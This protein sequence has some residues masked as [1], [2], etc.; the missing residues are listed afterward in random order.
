MN[1]KL[2]LV[3]IFSMFMG[4]CFCQPVIMESKEDALKALR[5]TISDSNRQCVYN[6]LG[7]TYLVNSRYSKKLIDSAFYYLR[8]AVDLGDSANLNNNGITNESLC[9][10]AQTYLWSGDFPNARRLYLQVITSYHNHKEKAKEASTWYRMGREFWV[11]GC[12]YVDVPDCYDRAIRLFEQVKNIPSQVEVMIDKKIFFSS[13]GN[14]LAEETVLQKIKAL[15]KSDN[16]QNFS[17]IYAKLA[18]EDRY[19]GNLNKALEYALEAVKYIAFETNTTNIARCYAEIALI[20]DDL[21]EPEKSI[22][23]YQK[24]IMERE[25]NGYPLY[26]FYR[27]VS[28]YVIQMVK[29]KRENEAIAMLQKLAR[30]RPPV[31][32]KEKGSLFQSFAY[33]YAAMKAYKLAETKFLQMI[34]EYAAGESNAEILSIAYY[35]ISKFYVDNGQYAKASLYLPK[36]VEYGGTTISVHKNLFLL[37]F[38]VDSAKGKLASAITYYQKYKELNDTIFSEAKSRQINELMIRYESEK[39][40][41]NIKSL[42]NET[43]KQHG[44]LVQ[45][46]QTRNFIFGVAMLLLII[47]GLL[48]ANSRLKQRTNKKLHTHQVEIEKKNESLLALLEEKDWLV[49]EIH[50][51]VKNNFHMV[52][53]LLGTQVAYLKNEEAIGAMADSQQRILA[54]S[55]I[56]QKLYQSEN[57]SDIN[58]ADYIHELVNYL[59]DA[60]DTGFKVQFHFTLDQIALGVNYAVPVG[61]ILNEAITNAIK[62]AFRNSNGNIW[63]AFTECRDHT[64]QL[65]LS[66]KDDGIG[67]PEGFD[68]DS[69]SS[70]GMNLMKGLAKDI[71]SQFYINGSTG[72][73]VEIRFTIQQEMRKHYSMAEKQKQQFV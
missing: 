65:F 15:A 2:L 22:V 41:N 45:A 13:L 59:R 49:K 21:G 71:D 28:L 16:L 52:I 42:E 40:D 10:L 61:L 11:Q 64:H 39:K 1:G 17:W 51:R 46:N 67:L 20:Y 50:H 24:C 18:T 66:V 53:G 36:A 55:L 43:I 73:T 12:T 38:K 35:D 69:R 4:R 5:Q 6:Y 68:Y 58:M 47:S 44:K 63:I 72:T 62:Y 34:S 26:Y 57:M 14:I 70:M 27:T 29:V 3:Y 48:I 33:C 9:L 32:H 56:H 37:Q 7:T 30:T 19:N 23:W 8:K 60:L 31:S 54:M 25:R